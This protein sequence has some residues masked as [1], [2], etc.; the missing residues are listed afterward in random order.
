MF[1]SASC[2]AA[3]KADSWLLF[4]VQHKHE[5]I[6]NDD[7]SNKN[8]NNNKG[9]MKSNNEYDEKLILI[10]RTKCENEYQIELSI[11]QFVKW[12][13]EYLRLRLLK[14]EG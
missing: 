4:I 12:E 5:M 11:K 2:L 10:K 9:I 6:N 7:K 8:N 13:S 1:A 3:T 14:H